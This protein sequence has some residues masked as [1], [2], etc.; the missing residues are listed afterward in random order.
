MPYHFGITLD[1]FH[2]RV[3]TC[4]YAHQFRRSHTAE[5]VKQAT[6]EMLNACEIDKQRLLRDN[7]RNMKKA[8]DDM[9][10][11]SV[12]CISLTLQ[13][14]EHE[15]LLSQCSVTDSTANT[16]KVVGQCLN[17]ICRI[18]KSHM[19][20]ILCFNKIKKNIKEC[21]YFFLNAAVLSRKILVKAEYGIG[22]RYRIGVRKNLIG[23]SLLKCPYSMI[24]N[25]C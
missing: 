11:P 18:R 8:M 24:L 10:V 21:R 19:K 16:K 13:L 1:L 3:S 23:T 9:E 2:F 25:P 6:E 5:H 4:R 20:D 12:G 15:G 17:S 14:A 7:V 22:T